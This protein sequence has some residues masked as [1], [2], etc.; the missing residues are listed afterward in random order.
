MINNEPTPYNPP[1]KEFR[2]DLIAIWR[3]FKGKSRDRLRASLKASRMRYRKALGRD[4]LTE[5]E[6]YDDIKDETSV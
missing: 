6:L 2:I 4:D 3:Y 1:H 5:A